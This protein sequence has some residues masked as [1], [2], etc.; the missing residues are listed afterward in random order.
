MPRSTSSVFVNWI[1]EYSTTWTWLP[2]GSR[3]SSRA[4]RLDVDAGL[5]QSLPSRL[6]VVDDEPEVPVCVGL[7][8]AAGRESDEL[9]AHVD[10]GHPRAA[11]PAELEL[12]DA[13]VE[14]ER[15]L[16]VADLERNVVQADERRS[17]PH[18]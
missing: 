8:R 11:S 13:P 1:S 7:L 10:E 3:K 14:L 16:D 15:L 18:P 5:L 9:V 4:R 17:I 6:L 2:H 12:E